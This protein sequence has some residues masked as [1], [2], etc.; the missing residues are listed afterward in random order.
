MERLVVRNEVFC[1]KGLMYSLKK[2]K[3]F[4]KKKCKV[5][6]VN[7]IWFVIGEEDIVKVMFKLVILYWVSGINNVMIVLFI[8][9][10]FVE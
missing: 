5:D 10:V 3:L 8:V 1:V 7:G 4:S 9:K 2:D 6:E